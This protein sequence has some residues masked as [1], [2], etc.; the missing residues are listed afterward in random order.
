MFQSR[1]NMLISAAT[2][3]EK[4]MHAIGKLYQPMP[5]APNMIAWHDLQFTNARPCGAKHVPAVRISANNATNNA[6]NAATVH[7]WKWDH[8]NGRMRRCVHTVP[9]DCQN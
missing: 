1:M 2:E 9:M 7:T 3:V 5:N 6:D 8:V 4:D